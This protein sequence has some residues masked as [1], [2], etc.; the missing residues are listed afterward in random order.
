MA[1]SQAHDID[2]PGLLSLLTRD[3]IIVIAALTLWAASDAWFQVT[4]LW[5]AELLSAADGIVVGYIV[6]AITHEWG[7]YLG[8]RASGA[9]TTRTLP[10]NLTNLFRFSFDFDNNSSAQFH[11]KSFSGWIGHWAMLL[12]IFIILPMDTLGRAALVSALFGFAIFATVVETGVLRKTFRGAKPAKA[13]AEQSKQNLLQAGIAGSLS[14]VLAF[15][16]LA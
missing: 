1:A 4:G 13:L 14:G 6:A 11:S 12:L 10:K 8:A 9:H 15:T 5:A 7:H 2:E 3:A 16:A